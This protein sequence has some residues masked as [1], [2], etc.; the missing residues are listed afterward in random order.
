MPDSKG[1]ENESDFLLDGRCSLE[2]YYLRILWRWRGM[3]V[4]R[5]KT[6][7]CYKWPIKNSKPSRN[8]W[9]C[10]DLID[11]FLFWVV[12]PPI[13]GAEKIFDLPFYYFLECA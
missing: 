4:R 8:S 1:P 2:K 10:V 13:Q 6:L 7:D 3:G 11:N 9:K 12:E 5:V